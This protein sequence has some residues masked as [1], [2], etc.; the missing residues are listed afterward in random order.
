MFMEIKCAW[1]GKFLGN[2]ECESQIDKAYSIS[3]SICP[4]CKVQVEIETE[5]FFKQQQTNS[6]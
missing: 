1:C 2:K 5:N 3:H 4:E 6:E